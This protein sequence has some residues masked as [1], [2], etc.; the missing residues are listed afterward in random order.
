MGLLG[1]K[2]ERS[3]SPAHPSS[4]WTP[5]VPCAHLGTQSH[6]GLAHSWPCPTATEAPGAITPKTYPKPKAFQSHPARRAGRQLSCHVPILTLHS[7]QGR[8]I[9]PLLPWER[10]PPGSP[11]LGMGPRSCAKALGPPRAALQA[12]GLSTLC[13]LFAKGCGCR[14]CVGK[15][16]PLPP[17]G[18]VASPSD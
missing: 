18:A 9:S 11:A 8:A 14:S 17:E 15:D 6:A 5:L 3:C 13:A 10:A 16:F 1:N 12:A 2:G 7:C 4:A